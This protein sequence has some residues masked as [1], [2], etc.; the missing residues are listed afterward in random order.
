MDRMS[1]FA[2]LTVSFP[3][4]FLDIYV[5]FVLM[6]Q[7]NKLYLDDKMN[8]RRLIITV[9]LM[10]AA[11]VTTRAVMPNIMLI[12]GPIIILYAAIFKFVYRL[13]WSEAFLVSILIYGVLIT[14]EAAYL[15]QY[16]KFINKMSILWP[17]DITRLVMTIPERVIQIIII[18]SFWKW[19]LAYLN[20]KSSKKALYTFILLVVL[21]LSTEFAFIFAFLYYFDN[22]SMILKIASS[23]ACLVFAVI[24]VLLFKVV[25]MLS[26]N[27]NYKK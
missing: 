5:A 16:V 19:D 22:M 9:V 8:I 2:V 20:L 18:V 13:K 12:F 17:D 14:I 15:S 25:T 3:E 6:G 11:S 10:V 23:A 21:L 4:A 1:L 27:G 24:N 7:R 26:K